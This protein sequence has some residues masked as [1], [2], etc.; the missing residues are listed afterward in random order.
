MKSFIASK[1]VSICTL[2][3]DSRNKVICDCFV[4]KSP[5]F[6]INDPIFFLDVHT[7][8]SHLLS[9]IIEKNSFRK[10]VKLMN[11][12][13]D[14]EVTAVYSSSIMPESDEGSKQV[15]EEELGT[16]MNIE[17]VE[18]YMAFIDPRSRLLGTRTIASA[19]SI[20][21][22]SE[23]VNEGVEF[24]KIIRILAGV[25]EGPSAEGQNPIHLCFDK[26]NFIHS[27]EKEGLEKDFGRTGTLPFVITNEPQKVRDIIG[28]PMW[29]AQKEF[30]H[31]AEGKIFDK[32][33]K[34]IGNVIESC[35][36]VGLGKGN[37]EKFLEGC[38]LED[39]RTL[40]FWNPLHMID[41]KKLNDSLKP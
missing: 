32:D 9:S 14:M 1:K 38:F 34:V 8:H 15:W 39:G 16:E 30:I 27:D 20:E 13:A 33:H 4:I 37:I 41:L 6:S 24:Y 25:A 12:E 17:D 29:L 23:M 19:G 2:L 28:I 40:F 10:N 35:K 7:S 3:L 36:N 22:S 31:K 21:F 18:G 11:L 5:D 26:L